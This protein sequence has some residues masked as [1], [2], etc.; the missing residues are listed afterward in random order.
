MQGEEALAYGAWAAGV[1]VVTGYPGSPSSGVVQHLLTLDA[2]EDIHIQ[3]SANEKVAFETA[4][5]VSVM[6]QRSLVCLKS[7]GLN[8]ALDPIMTA[9]LTGVR[10]GLV[11][12]LGDDPGAWASQNE[13]DSRILAAFAELPLL[14]P[15]TPAE[16]TTMIGSAF[17]LSEDVGLP[18]FVRETRDFSRQTGEVSALSPKPFT[19]SDY[20]HEGLRWVS[21]P[22]NVVANHRRLHR[23]LMATADRFN[24]SHF[25]VA[26]GEGPVGVLA[27]GFAHAKL[28][29][30]FP[31]GIPAGVGVLKLGT[32]HPLPEQLLLSFMSDKHQLLVI[33]E[34]EPLVEMQLRS[35]AQRHGLTLGILG[36]QTGSLPREGALTAERIRTA[37]E[38]LRDER[39]KP[40]SDATGTTV[41]RPS[42]QSICQGCFY[43]PLFA[44]LKDALVAADQQAVVC[45]DPGCGIRI[46]Q[47]PFEMLDVKHCMGS[48]IAIASGLSLAGSSVLPIALVGDSSFF[49]SG[50]NGL[51]SAVASRSSMFVLILS[52]GSAALTGAQ[53]HPGSGYDARGAPA[54]Q[55]RLECILRACG[56]HQI[57]MVDP[58][59]RPSTLRALKAAVLSSDLRAVI[60]QGVCVRETYP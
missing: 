40:R 35:L 54:P 26:E 16:A 52:N 58:L 36:K 5:G 25:N 12:L 47:A 20:I 8:V 24:H 39:L 7:V 38:Q 59:D 19:H 21:L 48:A 17:D 53:P 29:E 13:Q 60:A 45:A 23:R 1:R 4:L 2:S 22:F 43:A 6:G 46:H 15:A 32:V 37:L 49:H 31:C 42:Q 30:G 9:N 55:V 14:E 51:I 3:W 50:L 28:I 33:E 11:I 57:T 41:A 56:V 27:V 10:G 18:V 44:A 34:T